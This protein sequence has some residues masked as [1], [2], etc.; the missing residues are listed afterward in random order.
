MRLTD[1]QADRLATLGSQAL[2]IARGRDGVWVETKPT[3]VVLHTRLAEDAVAGPAE[4]EAVALGERLGAGVLHGRDI[5]EMSVLPA[6]KGEA[7]IALRDELGTPVVL[8]AGD[9]VTDEHAFEVLGPQ[10]L[11]IKVGQG[12]S[13]AR[14]RVDSP[15]ESRGGSRGTRR[16]PLRGVPS[17]P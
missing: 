6:N 9:D 7:L 1:E 4:E 3:A 14:F 5:V 10:D 16:R 8:Y 11:T 12:D 2:R 17:G 15:E 13:A